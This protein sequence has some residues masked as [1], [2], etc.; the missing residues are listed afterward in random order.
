M[1]DRQKMYSILCAAASRAI[2]AKDLDEA[3]R[4]LQAALNEAEELYIETVGGIEAAIEDQ[5]GGF[6]HDL[7]DKLLREYPA[8]KV[9]SAIFLLQGELRQSQ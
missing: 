4:I 5:K 2:D 6:V 7:V 9:Y 1:P 3:R 8:D